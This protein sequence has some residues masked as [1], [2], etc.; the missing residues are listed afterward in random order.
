[1]ALIH[2]IKVIF[3]M[4]HRLSSTRVGCEESDAPSA[5][6]DGELV[7]SRTPF[8]IGR[9]PVDAQQ[10]ERGLPHELARLLVDG[11]LPHVRVPVLRARHDPVRDGRPVDG[12]DQFVVL[13]VLWFME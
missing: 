9:G 5:A 12:G 13:C 8:N 2:E 10:H 3:L 4:S 7:L 6:R 1:M 11:L